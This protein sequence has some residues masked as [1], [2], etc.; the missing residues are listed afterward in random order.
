MTYRDAIDYVQNST[1]IDFTEALER[2]KQRARAGEKIN[3]AVKVLTPNAK[4]AAKVADPMKLYRANETKVR[5][6]VAT[7]ATI[8]EIADALNIS[9]PTAQSMLRRA[10]LKTARAHAKAKDCDTTEAV[11]KFINR[12]YAENYEMP[13]MREIAAGVTGITSTSHAHYHAK[14]LIGDGRLVIVSGAGTHRAFAPAWVVAAIKERA[15]KE[16]LL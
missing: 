1:F 10:G 4:P 14:R 6:M 15:A 16:G 2:M 7:N 3:P 13:T 5:G 12:F 8:K 11:M 9:V